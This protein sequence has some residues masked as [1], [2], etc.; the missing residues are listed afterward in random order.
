MR[1]LPLIIPFSL[2]I[3]LRQSFNA[4]FL[5]AA[6]FSGT[7]R[8]AGFS[9]AQLSCKI[10]EKVLIRTA[11]F[12]DSLDPHAQPSL[13]PAYDLVSGSVRDRFHADENMFVQSRVFHF[14]VP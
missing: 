5:E 11:L 2:Q 3:F 13:F 6:F 7:N 14:H 9:D 4:N 12:R 10:L 8:Q 1:Q